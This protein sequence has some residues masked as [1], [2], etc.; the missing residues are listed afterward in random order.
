MTRIHLLVLI[1]CAIPLRAQTA[2]EILL[3]TRRVIESHK[4]IS[5][6]ALGRWQHTEF[7]DTA[8]I[9]GECTLVRDTTDKFFGGKVLIRVGDSVIKFYA[10]RT[11]Y[12][13]DPETGATTSYNAGEGR[14]WPI[15][16]DLTERIYWSSFLKPWYLVPEAAEL[17]RLED[18]LV[19][20]THAYHI[21]MKRKGDAQLRG[22]EQHLYISKIDH[23]PLL[24]QRQFE[25]KDNPQFQERRILTYRFDVPDDLQLDRILPPNAHIQGYVP[26]DENAIMMQ[27]GSVQSGA[28]SVPGSPGTR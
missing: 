12:E 6:T 3:S 1:L 18:T 9:S 5:Y 17:S 28:L 2:D 26:E 16:T 13:I 4:S 19:G 24:E 22:D 27:L 23:V 21:V 25:F 15:I 11:V 7:D 20:D 10:L 14:I 8:K